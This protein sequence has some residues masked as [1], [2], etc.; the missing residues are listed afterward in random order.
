M[1]EVLQSRGI[2]EED[3]ATRQQRRSLQSLTR[4]LPRLRFRWKQL[5]PS[6]VKPTELRSPDQTGIR[7]R[8]SRMSQRKA[9][10]GKRAAFPT[11]SKRQ[12]SSVPDSSSLVK[13]FTHS[14]AKTKSIQENVSDSLPVVIDSPGE[15]LVRKRLEIGS[16]SFTGSRRTCRVDNATYTIRRVPQNYGGHSSPAMSSMELPAGSRK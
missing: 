15:P 1:Y 16:W 5:A 13:C 11:S 10:S 6:A 9:V 12:T 8:H 3:K 7:P 14:I 4:L 2:P